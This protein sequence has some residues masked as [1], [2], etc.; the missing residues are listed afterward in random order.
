MTF[1]LDEIPHFGVVHIEVNPDGRFWFAEGM[2]VD[3]GAQ[4]DTLE[5]AIKN[6]RTGL[7]ATIKLNLD[8]LGHV[9]GLKKTRIWK[10]AAI[11]AVMQFFNWGICTISWRAVA[12]ANFPAA[13]ITDTTLATLTFFLFR[14]IANSSHENAFIPWLG[15]TVGGV[16]GTIVGIYTSLIWLGK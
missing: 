4:G 10:D 11:L 8:R 14:K 3:Y 16:A 9:K 6:F 15:Y 7:E 2:E 12:Q 13:I 1:K 5:E